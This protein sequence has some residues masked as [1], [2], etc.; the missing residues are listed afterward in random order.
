MLDYKPNFPKLTG[1]I[2]KNIKKLLFQLNKLILLESLNTIL[3]GTGG[4]FSVL[5]PHHGHIK[6]SR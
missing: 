6:S 4:I 1:L 3:R 5:S 2:L